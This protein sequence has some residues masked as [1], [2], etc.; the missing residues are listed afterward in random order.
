MLADGVLSEDELEII[1]REAKR[2]HLS[3]EDVEVLIQQAR[4]E[5]EVVEDLAKLP[6]HII[7]SKPEHAIEHFKTLVSEIRQLALMTDS[8]EFEATAHDAGRLSVTEWQLWRQITSGSQP[9]Q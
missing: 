3:T 1:N 6:L 8:K 5:R 9:P 4:R 2:L 7:A